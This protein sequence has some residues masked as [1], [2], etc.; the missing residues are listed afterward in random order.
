MSLIAPDQMDYD[1]ALL[2]SDIPSLIL[3][4]IVLTS[5]WVHPHTQNMDMLSIRLPKHN[6][7]SGCWVAVAEH[8]SKFKFPPIALH[9]IRCWPFMSMT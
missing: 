2:L 3:Y 7:G 6:V 5:S 8:A 4:V 9:A 1:M